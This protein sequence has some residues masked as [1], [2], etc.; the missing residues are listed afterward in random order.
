MIGSGA[1]LVDGAPASPLARLSERAV[2]TVHGSLLPPAAPVQTWML[3][4]PLG[5]D[6][7]I[8]PDQPH[9]IARLL[10]ALPPGLFPAGRLDKDSSGLLL[11]TND[12]SL[13]Q[14]LLHPDGWHEKEYTITVDR[15]A[16]AQ[17]LEQLRAGTRYQVG[18]HWYRPRPCVATQI[19]PRE[20]RI[21]LTEGM[22]R[23]IRYMC[24]A[25]GLRVVELRRIRVNRL[26]LGHLEPGMVRELGPDDL[27]RLGA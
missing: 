17:Q 4:K 5:I 3:N 7:R 12:G 27:D 22:H 26:W 16:N 8:E 21:T 14:R 9:S 15:D 19:G 11:L 6:C 23:Q 2:V 13:C 20:L 25:A 24:R 18:P 1:V 10:A